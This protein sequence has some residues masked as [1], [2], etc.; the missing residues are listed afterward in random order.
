MATTTATQVT[1]GYSAQPFSVAGYHAEI[2]RV[3]A[4][5]ANDTCTIT[6]A[7]GR[8]VS[9]VIG[10]CFQHALGTAGTDSSVVL[11]YLDTVGS[12]KFVDVLLL[13][14]E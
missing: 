4:G 10:G 14:Q 11:T 8:F 7:R 12:N 3:P 2:W 1:S 6:P 9:S 5:S 13:I